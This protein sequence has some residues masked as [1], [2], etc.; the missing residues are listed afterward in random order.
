MIGLDRLMKIPGVVAAGQFSSEGKIIRKLG[1]IPDNVR[2]QVAQMN[3]EQTKNLNTK[4]EILGQLTGFEWT[5]MAGWMMWGSKYA[6]CVVH[7][8]CVIIESKHADL[9]Q[10]MV[11]LFCSEPTGGNPLLSGL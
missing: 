7:N 10:L 4:A 2:E 6:L 9:N 11:D 5:P 1:D 3:A 8:N